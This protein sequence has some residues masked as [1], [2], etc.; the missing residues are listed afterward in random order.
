MNP[1]EGMSEGLH[2][3]KSGLIRVL[4]FVED[5]V[6]KDILITGDYIMTP[7]SCIDEMEKALIGVRACREEILG[8]I[9]AFYSKHNFQSPQTYPEDFAFAVMKAIGASK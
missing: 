1:L 8:V 7:E 6:I 5:D 2:K 4:V 3:A 9:Q